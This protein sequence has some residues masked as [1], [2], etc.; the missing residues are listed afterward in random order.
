MRERIRNRGVVVV[1]GVGAGVG[2]AVVREFARREYALAL[3]SRG[4]EGSSRAE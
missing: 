1:S 4:V 2:R 3:L